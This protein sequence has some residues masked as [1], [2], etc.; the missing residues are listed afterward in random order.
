MTDLSGK[1]V[2]ITGV[3]SGMTRE[4]AAATAVDCGATVTGS[5]SSNTD[6]LI[7]GEKP[8]MKKVKQAKSLSIT[9]LNEKQWT[10]LIKSKK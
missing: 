4:E 8:G 1:T 7:V 5:V 2:V 9:V 3:L 10:A 6:Y